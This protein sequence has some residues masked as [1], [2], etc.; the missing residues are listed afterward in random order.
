[1]KITRKPDDRNLEGVEP[2]DAEFVPD[3]NNLVKVTLIGTLIDRV[4]GDHNVFRRTLETVPEIDANCFSLEAHRLPQFVQVISSVDTE[5][6]KL[7]LGHF[8]LD[9][10][11]EAYL[12]G[13][14]LFQR[15]AIIVGSTGSGK[16]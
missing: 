3:E 14:K 10:E 15:H 7:S 12:N 16:S 13:N 4:G 2:I 9:D 5:G 1:M 11:A 8:T 6:P